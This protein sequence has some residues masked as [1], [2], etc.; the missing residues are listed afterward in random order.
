[1]GYSVSDGA[2][3][4]TL[5]RDGSAIEVAG[6]GTFANA[7]NDSD[8]I[9]GYRFDGSF[10]R[11]EFGEHGFRCRTVVTGKRSIL[12]RISVRDDPDNPVLA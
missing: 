1:M 4:A 6:P 12:R 7:I 5:W 2:A 3:H 9:V 8:Q 10:S 11:V